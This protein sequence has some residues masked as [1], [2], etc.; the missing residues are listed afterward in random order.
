MRPLVLHSEI[1][2]LLL[3]GAIVLWVLIEYFLRVLASPEDEASSDWATF[4]V[5][6]VIPASEVVAI[7]V[8]IHNVAPLPGSAWWPVATGLALIWI[9][10][11]LRLWATLT[12]RSA[13]KAGGTKPEPQAKPEP[14]LVDYG[15]Y[16]WLRHPSYLGAIVGFIGIGFAGGVWTSVAV[17][18]I[19]AVTAFLIRIRVEE[20]ALLRTLGD[21]YEIYARRTARLI[22]R[23]Y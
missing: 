22:P 13:N 16:R 21:E 7:V 14:Q 2:G 3:G 17:M 23:V 18:L 4:F 20:R 6:I 9:G 8:V 19:G 10:M 5:L 12:L 11:A 1:A 15:P